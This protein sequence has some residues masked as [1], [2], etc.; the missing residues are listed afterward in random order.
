ME[1]R[2]A[3]R[4]TGAIRDFRDAPV[5]DEVLQAILEDAR[6]APSGGNRQAWHLIVVKDHATRVALRDLYLDGWHDYIAHH[7][8]GLLPFSPLASDEDRRAAEA[9]RADAEALS[10]PTGFAERLD[11]SPVLLVLLADLSALAAIDRDLG[12]YTITGGASIYPFAWSILLAAREHGLG[13]VM[14]TIATRNEPAVQELL[15][16]PSHFATASVIALG[17]PVK[18]FTKLKRR[19]VASFTTVDRYDGPAF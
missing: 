1:L 2:D 10:Q 17:Y 19:E 4:T 3:L 6:F 7:L 13:G 15:G 16:V 9:K 14:T 12:R 5:T 11:K 18:E 8:A